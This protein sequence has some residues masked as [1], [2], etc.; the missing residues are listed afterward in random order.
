MKHTFL[1]QRWKDN[2]GAMYIYMHIIA[3][4]SGWVGV[5]VGNV[6]QVYSKT[7]IVYMK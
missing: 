1:A 6:E 5:G 2:V 7:T 4:T 3:K